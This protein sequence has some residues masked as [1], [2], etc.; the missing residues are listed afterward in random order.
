MLLSL[1]IFRKN[2]NGQESNTII[3][4]FTTTVVGL[5]IGITAYFLSMMKNRWIHEDIKNIEY[6]TEGIMKNK[7]E[8]TTGGFGG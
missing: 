7:E 6:F 2:D 1:T 5:A 8:P 3:I 4:A